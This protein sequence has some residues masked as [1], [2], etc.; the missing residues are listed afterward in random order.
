MPVHHDIASI[1]HTM[2]PTGVSY[3]LPGELV[4]SFLVSTALVYPE[5]F[6]V[7][8][9]ICDRLKLVPVSSRE[10]V[11]W[12]PI[13]LETDITGSVIMT[14]CFLMMMTLYYRNLGTFHGTIIL[15]NFL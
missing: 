7:D 5:L 1:V 10:T 6:S 12:R 9:S 11:E 3:V 15:T 2:N 4:N 14:E 13:W 8:S